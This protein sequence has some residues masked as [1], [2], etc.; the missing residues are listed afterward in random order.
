VEISLKPM[1]IIKLLEVVPQGM[2]V[3]KDNVFMMVLD[4]RSSILALSK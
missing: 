4:K 2:E 3:Q 1:P